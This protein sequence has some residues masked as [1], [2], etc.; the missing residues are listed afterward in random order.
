MPANARKKKSTAYDP[1]TPGDVLPRDW[2]AV[3]KIAA[4]W[5]AG[6]RKA[7]TKRL[8]L[9]LAAGGLS[10]AEPI[11]RMM[12]VAWKARAIRS[13]WAVLGKSKYSPPD[14]G[15]SPPAKDAS[16]RGGAV[17]EFGDVLEK[18]LPPSRG[19]PASAGL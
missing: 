17:E 14:S 13:P 5:P 7:G 19:R 16:V 12:D 2:H 8:G 15:P 4:E 10:D 11:V 3:L 9:I 1:M 6:G 18:A